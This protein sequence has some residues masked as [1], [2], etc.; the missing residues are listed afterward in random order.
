VQRRPE[1]AEQL[2]GASAAGL[3]FFFIAGLTMYQLAVLERHASAADP[4]VTFVHVNVVEFG[5][6]GK[7][8]TA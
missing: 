6:A 7:Y 4:L 3:G 8:T 2:L 1:V 5:H